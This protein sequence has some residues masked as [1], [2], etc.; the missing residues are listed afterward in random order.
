MIDYWQ[1]DETV[2]YDDGDQSEGGRGPKLLAICETNDEAKLVADT[3][4]QLT[5]QRNEAYQIIKVLISKTNEYTNKQFLEA[6]DK[7]REILKEKLTQIN[8]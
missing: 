7:A 1:E 6:C 3:L 2:M 5:K 4:N 8:S